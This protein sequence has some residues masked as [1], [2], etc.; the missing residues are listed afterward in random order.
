MITWLTAPH[1][2]FYPPSK[3]PL[4]SG[5]GKP[6][7]LLRKMT[8]HEGHIHLPHPV[9][10]Q[11]LHFRLHANYFLLPWKIHKEIS[12]QS[13]VSITKGSICHINTLSTFYQLWIDQKFDAL[14]KYLICFIFA[15][16]ALLPSKAEILNHH[17][18]PALDQNTR[19]WV[20][21]DLF[22]YSF[23]FLMSQIMRYKEACHII[24]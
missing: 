14:W 4:F 12:R 17:F 3:P 10:T 19:K 20:A 6:W 8:V 2:F 21:L 24:A 18:P 11:Y 22:I 15:D 5:N 13:C 1:I 7:H 16:T 23:T 9:K